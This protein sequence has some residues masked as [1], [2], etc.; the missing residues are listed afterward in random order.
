MFRA[1]SGALALALT[2]LVLNWFLPTLLQAI[3]DVALKLLQLLSNA[4]DNLPPAM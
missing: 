1:F 4:L 3:V 2:L